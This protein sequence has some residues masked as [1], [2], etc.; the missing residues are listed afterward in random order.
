MPNKYPVSSAV[1]SSLR[2][3]AGFWRA[4]GYKALSQELSV[5]RGS[6]FLAKAVRAGGADALGAGSPVQGR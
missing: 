6:V 4:S 2:R 5:L 1:N 3:F